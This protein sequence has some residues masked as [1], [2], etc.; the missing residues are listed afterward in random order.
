MQHIW[1]V[2]ARA[3]SS[4]GLPRR[5]SRKAK[6]RIV[7]SARIGGVLLSLTVLPVLPATAGAQPTGCQTGT[8]T[9]GYTGAEQC[10]AVPS[11]ITELDVVA[12]GAQGG[13]R[14]Y[15]GGVG[16]GGGEV[17]SVVDVPAGVSTLYVEVGGTPAGSSGGFNGGGNGGA[18]VYIGAAGSGGGG[19]TDLRTAAAASSGSAASRL[20]VAAGGG[21]IGG[22]TTALSTGGGVGG[23]LSDG[24]GTNGNQG[25]AGFGFN[26]SGYGGYGATPTTA[27]AGGAGYNYYN[28]YVG[29]SGGTGSAGSGGGGG[30]AYYSGGGGGG[31]GGGYYGGGGGG[32]GT[33]G[34]SGGYGYFGSGGSG[35]GGSSFGPTGSGFSAALA[36]APASLSITPV[37]KDLA[38]SGVPGSMSTDAAGPSGAVVTY[39]LP[40]ATDEDLSTVTVGCV[41]ESGSTFA[42]GMTTVTC[43]ATD[44]DGDTNSPVTQTFQVTVKGAADQ[45]SDLHTA[46]DGVGPGTSLA[47]KVASVQSY[48]AAGDASDACGTLSAFVH[49]VQAQSGKHIPAVQA[50]GLIADAQRIEAV[51]PCTS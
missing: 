26:P 23:A 6:V 12:T 34:F 40:T 37:D 7:A 22:P 10:Y 24:S 43:T 41:P 50:G 8:V 47:D 33:L 13:G 31:G 42:I 14:G 44:T 32:G 27:G 49:E 30:S 4:R 9:F 29:Q 36:G 1:D 38:L 39:T 51:I 21:G 18:R 35:G 28:S 45:L 3:R 17:T 25:L 19:A 11:G 2:D 48:L 46:V 15:I 5:L 16:G 20:V